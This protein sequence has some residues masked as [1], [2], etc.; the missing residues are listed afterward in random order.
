MNK[1]ITVDITY[2]LKIEMAPGD[3]PEDI[4]SEMDV[5]FAWPETQA[6]VTNYTI[7]DKEWWESIW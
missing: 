3:N 6:V 5:D 2:C 4:L 7:M 1:V